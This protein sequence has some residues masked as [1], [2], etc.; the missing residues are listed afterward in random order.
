[1]HRVLGGCAMKGN[2]WVDPAPF[3]GARPQVPWWVWLPGWVKLV[4]A[5]F[6][7]LWLALR[8]A[9][10]FVMLTV[11][12]PIAVTAGLG[13]DVAYRQFGLSPLVL[14]LLSL[15]CA[16]TVWY[17]LDRDS[18]LRHGWYRVLTEWRRLSVYV[19]QWRTVMRLAEMTKEVRGKEY[20]PKLRRVRS[21]GWRD[22]VR[23][24]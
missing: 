17:G 3:E 6:A 2:R 23:V 7:L 16:L 4:L 24:G 11:R 21:E 20:L 18:F 14:A 1:M 8:L 19:P 9:A 5:P 15:V 13:G 22:K 12:Y 10:K